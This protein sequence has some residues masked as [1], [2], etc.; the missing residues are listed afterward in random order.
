MISDMLS[1]KKCNPM[2]AELFIRGENKTFLLLLSHNLIL[3][4]QQMLD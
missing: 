1:N 4:C 2:I 3:L